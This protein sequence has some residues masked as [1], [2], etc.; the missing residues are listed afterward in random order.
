MFLVFI[1]IVIAFVV[2][3]YHI[4]LTVLILNSLHD[5]NFIRIRPLDPP[6][7]RVYGVSFSLPLACARFLAF[8]VIAFGVILYLIA[9]IVII[10]FIVFIPNPVHE[11]NFIRIRKLDPPPIR[12]SNARKIG[13]EGTDAGVR[14]SESLRFEYKKVSITSEPTIR[15]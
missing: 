9:I 11:D 3:L 5:M 10:V 4:V 14:D 13:L 2:I 8:I 15:P 12:A 1:V 6:P 7:F